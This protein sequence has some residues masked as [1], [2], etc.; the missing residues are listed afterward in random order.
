[1][2]GPPRFGLTIRHG[3]NWFR[4]PEGRVNWWFFKNPLGQLDSINAY[5]READSGRAFFRTGQ[6]QGYNMT[7]SGGSSS[8]RYF[9]S[10]GYD[11]DEGTVSYDW[12][13]R[14]SSRVNLTVLPSDK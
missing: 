11:R 9:A 6:P 12:R 1:M 3:A 13:N 14:L 2:E 5:Q 10:A 4:N 8:L 7:M